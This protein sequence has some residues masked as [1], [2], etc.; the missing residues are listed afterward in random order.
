MRR[1][2]KKIS[3]K[4]LEEFFSVDANYLKNAKKNFI[5][6]YEAKFPKKIPGFRAM[7]FKYGL[8]GILI[9]IATNAGA[10]VLADY[11]DLG[12]NH[13]LYGY[14]RTAETVKTVLASQEKQPGVHYSL[15]QRRMKEIDDIE[16]NADHDSDKEE[17]ISNLN[18]DFQ[19]EL[20]VALD[21]IDNPKISK[22]EKEKLCQLIDNILD[23]HNKDEHLEKY[24]NSNFDKKCKQ[25]PDNTDTN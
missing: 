17:K 9:L 14:K 13:P 6:S 5:A 8:A 21:K 23:E 11:K 3:S 19:K 20:D 1:I 10:I 2:H 22:R 12:A 16:N 7:V 18:K 15:A 4:A 24:E 25:T